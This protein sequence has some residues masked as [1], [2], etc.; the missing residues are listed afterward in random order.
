[1]QEETNENMNDIARKAIAL[2][3]LGI[4]PVQGENLREFV[5]R[6]EKLLKEIL[7]KERAEEEEYVSE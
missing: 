6:G 2:L 5:E 4:E 7:A 1:M 3:A